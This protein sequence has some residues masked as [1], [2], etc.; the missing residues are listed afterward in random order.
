[1]LSIRTGAVGLTEF[2]APLYGP[3]PAPLNAATE[4]V[5]DVPFVRPD[6]VTGDDAPQPVKQPGEDFTV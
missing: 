4:K 1:M 3:V 6:T 5:Y 2:D